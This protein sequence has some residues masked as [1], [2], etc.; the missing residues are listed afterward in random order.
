MM[1]LDEVDPRQTTA[2]VM[3]L[4]GSNLGGNQHFRRLTRDLRSHAA[5]RMR[6]G[7]RRAGGAAVRAPG[8]VRAAVIKRHIMGGER[9]L[10]ARCPRR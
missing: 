9:A 10:Q 4:V 6:L 8:R 3:T 7:K 2:T 5:V 1:R